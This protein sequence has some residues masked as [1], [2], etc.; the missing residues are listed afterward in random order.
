MAYVF[1]DIATTGLS[2]TADEILEI[3]IVGDDGA[4]LLNTLVSPGARIANWRS[5]QAIHRITPEMVQDSPTLEQ[6]KPTIRQIVEGKDVV[7]YN[8]DFDTG[9]LSDGYLQ[10][11]SSINCAMIRYSDH[12]GE[13]SE[14]LGNKWQKLVVA[15]L[16]TRYKWEGA[17]HRA[18]GNAKACRH[19]WLWLSENEQRP[20]EH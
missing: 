2:P 3:A 19:V 4:T 12:C 20:I 10:T 14:Y 7:I 1:L 15:A 17:R 13:W 16:N 6:L 9:F 11:A 8:A 18:L 5:A